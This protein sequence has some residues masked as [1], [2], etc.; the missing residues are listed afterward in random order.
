MDLSSY[1]K[2]SKLWVFQSE[3]PFS[4]FEDEIKERL[5]NFIAQWKTHGERVEATFDVLEGVF[6]IVASNEQ[7]VVVSGCGIDELTK[8]I[9][10][11]ELDFSLNLYDRSELYFLNEGELNSC[12]FMEVKEKFL[13]EEISESSQIFD[14]SVNTVES[15][16]NRWK[17]PMN[18]SWVYK[19]LIM[20][21]AP[22]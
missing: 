22:D 17:I 7:N 20:G 4:S 19:R 16:T 13:N 12:S 15:Y 3:S 21:G 18:R 8:C 14:I 6:I 2:E 5:E 10:N 1:K 9:Q 11:I